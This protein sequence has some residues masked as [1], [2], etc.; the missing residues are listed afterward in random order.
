MNRSSSALLLWL[1]MSFVQ[2]S[3]TKLENDE[4]TLNESPPNYPGNSW[5]QVRDV[6]AAGWSAVLLD[7]ARDYAEDISSNAVMII[8]NGKLIQA[9]GNTKEKYYVASIRKSFLGVLYDIP[10]SNGSVSL[11]ATLAE[12]GID[13]TSPALSEEEKKATVRDL[14]RSSSGVYHASAASDADDLPQRGSHSPGSYF[15]YNN[16]DFNALGTIFEIRT[17]LS[18]YD[19]FQKYIAEPTGMEDF[20]IRDGR[21]DSINASIHRAYHFDMTARDMARFGLLCLRE[22]EWNGKQLISREWMNEST[23]TKVAFSARNGGDDYTGGYGYLW[24]INTLRDAGLTE[25][26]YSAQG[27]Y[28]QAIFVLPAKNLVIVHRGKVSALKEISGTE[29]Y[30][31]LKKI[32]AA[33]N[34]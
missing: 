22:G 11:D 16:W 20:V 28:A 15:Y 32:L 18:I 34:N 25:G 7:E 3:C 4:Y 17:G 29:V 26:D 23:T 33:K 30:V 10:V 21:Y 27:N 1:L 31:L 6:T 14:L 13:D 24:W 19:A 9:W 2:M 5:E 12:Y 8:D